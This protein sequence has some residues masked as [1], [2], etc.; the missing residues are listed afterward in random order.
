MS[1]VGG[2]GVGSGQQLR[3]QEVERM[4][5]E[6]TPTRR[7]YKAKTRLKATQIGNLRNLM[8]RTYLEVEDRSLKE[9][10]GPLKKAF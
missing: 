10:F 3:L 6:A 4:A 8:A 5:L 9:E 2:R 1:R 7:R